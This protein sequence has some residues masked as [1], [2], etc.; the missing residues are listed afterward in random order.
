[1]L[2]LLL[3]PRNRRN[4]FGQGPRIAA[5]GKITQLARQSLARFTVLL[6]FILHPL[7]G[8]GQL[9]TLRHSHPQR[10]TQLVH[11]LL[12]NTAGLFEFGSAVGR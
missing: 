9:L 4:H 2:F 3:Q 8:I 12:I 6:K 1:L 5:L 7:Q 10:F 11:L